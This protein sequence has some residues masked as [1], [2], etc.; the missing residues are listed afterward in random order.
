MASGVAG[1]P[2][3]SSVAT[4]RLPYTLAVFAVLGMVCGST[5]LVI[6]SGELSNGESMRDTRARIRI[7]E[8]L[9]WQFF[10]TKK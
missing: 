5:P 8:V 9:W 4:R 3:S 10:A 2:C 6:S 1:S 7:G